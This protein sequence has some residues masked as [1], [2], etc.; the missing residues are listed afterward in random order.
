MKKEDF[1]KE[2]FQFIN[3]AT[4]SFTCVDTIK[5]EL[6]TKG[7]IQLYEN[8]KWHITSGNF[9]VTRNDASIIAFSIG[10]KHKDSFNIICTHSDTP[11]FS[12]KLK[13]EIYEN[14]YLKINVAPYGG[15]LNYG[16]MDRPLSISGRII[17][18]TK[19]KYIR[20]IINLEKPVF[21][22]PS[23]AIHQNDIANSNLDLNTQID[24]IPIISLTNEKDIIRKIL[25]K[26]LKL[27]DSNDICDYDLFLHTN[28]KPMFI[29]INNEMILSP[30][31]D[32][33][34]CTFATL[35]SFLESNNEKNI[36]IMCIFNS[37]EI[38][39]LTKEGADSSFLVDVLKRICASIDLDI[40]ITLHNSLIISA[41]N[42][43]AVHPNHPNKSDINN[44]GILNQGILVVREKDTTTDSISSTI[45]KEICKKANVP[46]Q[47]YASR[48][49][50]ATGSTLSGLCTRHVS[51]DSIDVGL[52]QLAMHSAN[53]VIG[54]TDPLYI[55][56]AF[57]KFYDISIKRDRDIIQIIEKYN[58]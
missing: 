20:K 38:G 34:T 1:N 39:S 11:G 29:G 7:Y 42:S 48:N 50:M 36:N 33:L 35:K 19:D 28:D 24:L 45:F 18:K 6:I 21:V 8:E 44:Q 27:D 25:K 16:W 46:F 23:E 51:I 58:S 54:D 9:F 15:I 31:L 26:H 2:L 56:I 57:K 40:S 12:L 49:D 52:P 43:H 47:D 4:C 22:I 30:R 10:E 32:D 53:E 41:D 13:N 17:Y 5:K 3:N 37:E 55:Y 14:N